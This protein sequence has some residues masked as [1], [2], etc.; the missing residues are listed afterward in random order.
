MKT[1]KK[2]R[3]QSVGMNTT[4]LPLL[5]QALSDP[6]FSVRTRAISAEWQYHD[7]FPMSYGGFN[8]LC[9]AAFTAQ[10]SVLC[11][12]LKDPR[13][14]IRELNESDQLIREIFFML[15]DYLHSWSYLAINELMP[16]L[17]FG[18]GEITRDNFEDFVFCHLLTETVA[19]IGV[20]YWYLSTVDLNAEL[21]LGSK[22]STLATGY[23]EKHR[24]EYSRFNSHLNVQSPLFFK[25]LCE[26]YCSGVFPGFT[27]ADLKRSP[28]TMSWLRHELTYGET[29]REYSRRWISH[30]SSG[31]VV[32]DAHSVGAAISTNQPWKLKLI[33][34]MGELLWAK[35]KT[36]VQHPFVFK[37]DQKKIWENSQVDRLDFRFT[38]LNRFKATAAA[39]TV[40]AGT[41]VD[42][43]FRYFF[44]QFVCAF[45]FQKFDPE[46]IKLFDFL[47][48]KKD[49]GLVQHLFRDQPR[50]PAGPREPRSLFFL[51]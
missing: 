14:S 4:K 13:Q 23:H 43:N 39:A 17:K 34:L 26:F 8:P 3:A 1:Q 42:E 31:Q 40:L 37:F 25:Q 12:W 7:I 21:D 10:D 30:L 46:L 24:A 44:Q 48:S 47:I 32:C 27:L 9:S 11:Q 2:S 33:E 18:Y 5:D 49:F 15:H 50:M 38:N 51:N 16:K 6:L 28:M 20:D 36:H 35:V 29:Q 19:T 22:F 41:E 45:D